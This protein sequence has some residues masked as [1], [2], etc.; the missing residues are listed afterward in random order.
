MW[1]SESTILNESRT[2]N[3]YLP[4]S[5]HQ[6]STT[7][8]NVIYLLDGSM[9]EDF[10][11]IVGNVQFCSFPWI[12]IIPESIVIGIAN[13]DRKRDFTYPS[14]YD[15]NQKEFPTSGKSSKFIEFIQKELQPYIH[16]NY[17]SSK[18]TTL[19]GQSLGGLL[20]TYL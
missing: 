19:I 9:D 20:A 12:N 7:N 4:A 15:L 5:Y 11:H 10:I 16:K 18:E 8:F 13:V 2:I 17:R 1:W 3:I 14:T 6:D